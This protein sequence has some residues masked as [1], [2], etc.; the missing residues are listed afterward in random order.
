MKKTHEKEKG[1]EHNILL[2]IHRIL[3]NELS[4][5]VTH[6]VHH[7]GVWN[8]KQYSIQLKTGKTAFMLYGFIDGAHPLA[9]YYAFLRKG[10]LPLARLSFSDLISDNG[11]L[12]VKMKDVALRCQEFIKIMDSPAE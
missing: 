5:L 11:S 10:R 8:G 7:P 3:T 6:D 9:P 2:A 12:V 1:K 4:G